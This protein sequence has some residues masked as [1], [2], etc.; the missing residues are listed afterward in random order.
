MMMTSLGDMI[1]NP[2]R[3]MGSGLFTPPVWFIKVKAEQVKRYRRDR[4][5][6]E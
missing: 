3:H 6:R 4:D 2:E 1:K 5:V